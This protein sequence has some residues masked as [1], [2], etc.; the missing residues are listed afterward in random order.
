MSA[1]R[2]LTRI[3]L[4]LLNPPVLVPPTPRYPLILYLAIQETFIKPQIVLV[5]YLLTSKSTPNQ[6]PN[7]SPRLIGTPSNRKPIKQWKS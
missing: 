7:L 1:K 6:T 2:P 4:Y 5:V 3:K